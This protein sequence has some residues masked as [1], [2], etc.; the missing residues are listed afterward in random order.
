MINRLEMDNLNY[1]VYDE[2]HV[3]PKRVK[4]GLHCII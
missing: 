4:D 3:E 2:C 1:D